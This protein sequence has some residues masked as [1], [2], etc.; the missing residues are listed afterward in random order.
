VEASSVTGVVTRPDHVIMRDGG[1]SAAIGGEVT[2]LFGDTIFTPSSCD[3]AKLRGSTAA[4]EVPDA[5]V[6]NV[7][8]PVDMC[9][10]PASLVTPQVP[11][12]PNGQRTAFWPD[13]IVPTLDGRAAVFYQR[14]LLDGDVWTVEATAVAEMT[15]GSTTLDRAGEVVLF[16]QGER[17]Y[18]SGNL[19]DNGYIYLYATEFH[20]NTNT[21]AYYLARVPHGQYRDRSAYTFWDGS[22]WSGDDMAAR[23]LVLNGDGAEAGGGL[24]GSSVSFNPYLHKYLM[25][26]SEAFKNDLM[27]RTADRPEGPWSTPTHV[28]VPDAVDS[29]FGNYCAR[30]HPE[31]RSADG[32]TIYLTYSRATG[33]L[34]GDIPVVKVMLK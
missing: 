22:S 16:H 21:T 29:I 28:D 32:R 4:V 2:W 9:G 8:E 5:T 1:I 31:F 11:N 24:A 14:V 12:G 33:P 23:Q 27:L 3:G 17:A 25:V 7:T 20:S 30:E 10:A 18:T 26:H 34:R 13:A 15:P 19:V 6:G